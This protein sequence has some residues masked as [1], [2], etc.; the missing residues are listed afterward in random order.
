[1]EE[2]ASTKPVPGAKKIGDPCFR[3]FYSCWYR[4]QISVLFSCHVFSVSF[5]LEFFLSL[6]LSSMT[7]LLFIKDSSNRRSL[8][9]VLSTGSYWVDSGRGFQPGNPHSC[10]CVLGRISHSQALG[11]FAP[12]DDDCFEHLVRFCWVLLL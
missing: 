7:L 11:I 10:H 4:V 3:A 9:L 5:N 6:S 2:L 8:T 1:M 12:I